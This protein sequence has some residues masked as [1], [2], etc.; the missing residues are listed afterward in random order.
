[1]PRGR[2]VLLP[3]SLCQ[4]KNALLFSVLVHEESKKET[5]KYYHINC[6]PYIR[7]INSK[8]SDIT[9]GK[10]HTQYMNNKSSNS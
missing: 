5:L 9:Q 10:P 3:C 1:M 6:K 2:E 4:L 8:N 7:Y